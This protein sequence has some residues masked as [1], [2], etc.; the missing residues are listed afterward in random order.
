LVI[1]IIQL[2]GIIVAGLS[3]GS[4]KSV[5]AV[6]I[7]A[8]LAAQGLNIAPF[9]KGP[10]Y[11]DAGWLQMA[12]G[13]QCHNLDPYLMSEDVIRCSFAEFSFGKDL[14]IVEG[15]RGLFDGVDTAGSYST[16]ELAAILEMPV[17]LSIDCTK[18]T[19]TVAAMVFGCQQLGADIEICGVVLNRIGSA[20]HERVVRQAVEEYTDVK[21]VGAIPRMAR[22]IFPQRHIGITPCPEY[23]GAAGAVKSL[24]KIICE[25]VDLDLVTKLAGTCTDVY[26][27]S[28]YD[29]WPKREGGKVKIG[30][31]RDAAFQFY[32]RKT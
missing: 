7:T 3:G 19:R 28:I 8:A 12:A 5:V 18:T 21:V 1:K 25:H 15:N 6:G 14:A 13:N 10:D 11:I 31:I 22:D 26:N 24:A 23:T 20:R 30:V 27:S 32:I 17:L 2:R 4:G 9:K 29:H 16:A